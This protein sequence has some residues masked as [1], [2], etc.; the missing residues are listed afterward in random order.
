MKL[1]RIHIPVL[2]AFFILLML[3]G[4]ASARAD[5]YE[6]DIEEGDGYQLNNYVIEITDVFV[7]A[8]TASYYVYEREKKVEDGLLDINESFEFDFDDDGEVQMRLKSVHAGVVPRATVEITISNYNIGDLYINDLVDGGHSAADFAGDPEIEITKTVDRSEIGIGET[9]TVT[10]NAKNAGN[11]AANNVLFTDPKQEHFVLEKTTYEVTG[12]VPEIDV[13]E[14]IPVYIY[15]LKATEAGTYDLKP[16]TASYTNSASQAYQSN[17]NTPTITISEGNKKSAQIETSMDVNLNSVE[18]NGKIVSTIILRNKGDADA[19]AVRL[20]LTLP[21]GLE[22][23]G[24]DEDIE[25]IGGNPRIYID[26]LQANNDKEYSYVLK[27]NEVGTY[28]IAGELS[29]E[30]NNEVDTENIKES[31][32]VKTS[33]IYVTKGKFDYLFEQPVYVYIIPLLILGAIGVHL[34]RKH[35]E[36]KY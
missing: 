20:D 31:A 36:Y 1:K 35:K 21:Q 22:Y 12:A 4:A 10:V 11:D 8:N 26:T 32:E 7:E 29:Y 30:Y 27:A 19:E 5:V 6:G 14:S 18:R 34:Y 15:E 23:E 9:I 28:T 13:G 24:G 2:C 33:S 16:V 17:S 25:L 3:G